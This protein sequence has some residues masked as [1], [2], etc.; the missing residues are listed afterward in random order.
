MTDTTAASTT[1]TDATTAQS[2]PTTAQSTPT[3]ATA[4]TAQGAGQLA[5]T[6]LNNDQMNA[7]T[8]TNIKNSV[9]PSL[10]ASETVTPVTQQVQDAEKLNYNN[11]D[12][13]ADQV[14]AN[15]SVAASTVNS[16]AQ[17]VNPATGITA[18]TYQATTVDPAQLAQ[19][20]QAVTASLPAG[21]LVS[22][23]LQSLLTPDANGNLPSWVQPAITAANQLLAG[24]GISNSTM[25]GQAITSAILTSAI[26]VAQ[27]NATA[28]Y[29]GWA[30]NLSNEQAAAMQN[31]QNE[32]NAI[33]SNQGAENAA[34]NFNATSEN[35]TNQYLASMAAQINQFNATQTNAINQFNSSQTQT[36]ATA[37][38]QLDSQLNQFNANMANQREQFNS[39]NSLIVQQSNAEYLR[40]VNTAN[41][42]SANQANQENAQNALGIS[43]AAMA[44]L[45]TQFNDEATMLYN[46]NMTVEQQNYS[47]AYLSQQYGL[48][49]QLDQ[50]ITDAQEGAALSQQI[51][52]FAGS[53]LNPVASAVG[54]S[55]G[56][57]VS[58]WLSGSGST[59]STDAT[60]AQSTL[61]TAQSTSS[62]DTGSS[63]IDSGSSGTSDASDWFSDS[64]DV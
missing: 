21:A 28:V 64:V 37:T 62:S 47:V 55:T 60:T 5:G 51:G 19:T 45:Q 10:S 61:T 63:L 13:T 3:S 56:K 38:A 22:N 29:N 41:T 44:N 14:N 52:K 50:N 43:N 20:T 6:Y 4:T 59:T 40:A 1:S 35:Q 57:A 26:P 58:S 15:Q 23:Q 11:L 32:A 2:T 25:A 7:V 31:G 53:L 49:N 24:R 17:A 48:Q 27:A 46:S 33:L 54:S 16:T 34:S 9:N 39:Q 30:Q 8:A 36:A 18:A 42:A 12:T